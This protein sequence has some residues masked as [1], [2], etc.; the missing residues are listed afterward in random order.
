VK[1][2]AISDMFEIESS[3][4]AQQK[5]D[6]ATKKFAAQMVTDHTKTSSELK[7]ILKGEKAELPQRARQLP[8]E[9]IGQAQRAE[10]RDFTKSI[11]A[12][13]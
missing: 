4:L 1:Q 9:Q 12:Y 11:A 13:K 2:V 3:K 10:R 5:A 8:S 7:G 6:E